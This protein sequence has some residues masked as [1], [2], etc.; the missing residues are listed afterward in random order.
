MRYSQENSDT[1]TTGYENLKP[2]LTNLHLKDTRTIDGPSCKFEWCELGT[3]DPD[4]TALFRS[5]ARDRT[6]VV[7]AAASHYEPPGR[8][9]CGWSADQLQEGAGAGGTRDG[10]DRLGNR[11]AQ[12]FAIA[13][14]H[15]GAGGVAEIPP[16]PPLDPIVYQAPTGVPVNP[17]PNR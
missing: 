9:A 17:T 13:A 3:G 10:C 12:D 1:V 7:I 6:D 15:C 14:Q 5:F 8:Y 16:I 4:Y 2:Y 11:C